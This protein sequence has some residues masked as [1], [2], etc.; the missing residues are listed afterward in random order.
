LSIAGFSGRRLAVVVAA[1]GLVA[2][3]CSSTPSKPSAQDVANDFFTGLTHDL[4]SGAQDTTNPTEAAK[5]IDGAHTALKPT[6]LVANNVDVSVNNNSASVTY[7][8]DWGFG[9]NRTWHDASNFLMSQDK[10]GNWKVN[11]QPGIIAP[12]LQAGESLKL[13]SNAQTELPTVLGGDGTT[14][15]A[16]TQVISVTLTPSQAGDIQ[17]AAT[18]LS[19]ALSQ[20]DPTITPQ[21]I[22][23]GASKAGSG[24]TTIVNLR[25][26]DYLKVKP[27]IYSLPGVSFPS[28]TELLA[29][30]KTFGSA[31]LPTIRTYANA[32]ASRSAPLSVY[33]QQAGGTPGDVLYTSASTT[34]Q[35]VPITTTLNTKLQTAAETA[36]ATVPL[37]AMAVVIQPSTGKILAVAENAA[38]GAAGDNPLTG[39]YPPG[40]TFKIV[41]ASA[42]F[43]EGK[44]APQQP[45]ACPGTTTIEGKVIPNEGQFNL[46][47]T[48]V[49][50]AFAQSCNT[51]FS[52][53]AA[54]LGPDDLPTTAKTFGIGV[55]YDMPNVVTNTGKITSD[56]DILA[57]AEDGFGQGRDQVSPFG[58]VLVAA[59]AEHG[60]TPVPSLIAGQTTR[61]DT[62]AKP[63]S[64]S[65]LTSLQALMRAVVTDGTGKPLAGITP[66]IYGKTGTAQFG[67]GSQSHGWFVGYQGDMAFAFVL[68]DAGT[69]APAVIVAGNFLANA[70]R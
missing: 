14:L 69:S 29:S 8:L 49:S 11:W 33:I 23:S 28:Q 32:Q 42:A 3:G 46:G 63:I 5:A 38:A 65:T 25:Q 57:R 45:I 34:A 19:A 20:F 53:V 7:T 59:T 21:S 30:T 16:P 56:T 35:P 4:H 41:T 68:V 55:N 26:S 47:T 9:P 62:P 27:Q 58:M 40:S 43:N 22:V 48:P 18:A 17:Q 12:K 60:S 54:G 10:D 52:Q 51:T 24:S 1:C 50:N 66:P 44:L 67:D 15:M 31:I 37:Q 61:S 2:A 70:D 6:T 13:N 64:S 36:L 39:L